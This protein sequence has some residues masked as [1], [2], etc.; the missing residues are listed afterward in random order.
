MAEQ[1]WD[2]TTRV[3][4]PVRQRLADCAKRYDWPGVFAILDAE[5]ALVNSVRPGGASWFAPL[6][7]AAHAGAA[8]AVVERLVGFGGWRGLRTAAGERPVDLA[9]RGKHTH[10]LDVLEPPRRADVPAETLRRIQVYFHA[11]IRARVQH[12]VDGHAL[13]LP[14]LEVLLELA[15]PRMVFPVPDL[16]GRFEF[17][18]EP[19]GPDSR[20]VV[21]AF[22]ERH[23]VTA[24]QV[25]LLAHPSPPLV[26]VPDAD[27]GFP[28][29]VTFAH[30]YNGYDLHGGPAGLNEVTIPVHREW[31]RTGDLPGD[32]DA[33]RACLFFQQRSHYWDGGLWDF[34]TEPFVVALLARIRALSGGTVP[35]RSV[36]PAPAGAGSTHPIR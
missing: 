18:L 8:V 20:L 33:L 1:T 2:G 16:H 3:T 12:L 9:R 28:E 22:A 5:P 25:R 32:V 23:E 26:R 34:E 17:R 13:R 21:D 14:E 36:K 11:V 6:H 31:K 30:T 19:A 7:Q 27:A 24:T 4:S 35:H 15:E 29:L 10:L